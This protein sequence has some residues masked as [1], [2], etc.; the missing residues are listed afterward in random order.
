MNIFDVSHGGADVPHEPFVLRLHE[1]IDHVLS[2][3]QGC[4]ICGR[5]L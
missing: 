3:F 1:E 2:T 4:Q 5:V